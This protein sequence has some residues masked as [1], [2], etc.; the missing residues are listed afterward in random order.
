MGRGLKVIGFQNV[1]SFRDR[2]GKVRFRYRR[3][4]EKTI[5][6]PGVPGSSEFAAA[7]Q[8]ATEGGGAKLVIGQGRTKPG[9][10]NAL[11][12]AIYSSAEWSLMAKTT[13]A[14]YRGIIERLRTDYGDLPVKGIRQSHILTMRDKRAATPTA[15]NNMVKVLRWMLQ[16][17]VAR[18]MR[19]DNP[20]I[21]VKP[22]R[23]ASEGFHTWTEAEIAT[24]EA[25]WDVGT[26][27]RLAFDLL[28]YTAQRSGDVR[29]M[30]RQHLK[31]GRIQVRQEKTGA[32]LELPIHPRL[33]ASL[34]EVPANQMLFLQTQAGVG[35]TA[36][37]FGNWFREACRSAGLGHCSAHG[38]RKSAATRLADAGASEAQIMAVTG[39]QTSKEVQR[40]T[41][42]RDQIR[43]ADAAMARIGGTKTEQEM[44]NLHTQLAKNGGK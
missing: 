28:L 11:A 22:L 26:R 31:A 9:T 14:T 6:L 27:E 18:Q 35:F 3:K 17:A 34:S 30:G 36:G 8:A 21:G 12:V 41:R 33:A 29:Q 7:Y 43:L 42:K 40:Y 15:A 19:D 39:H 4:G 23:I 2:H 38:L 20:A 16:F 32:E 44:A 13:Q 10:I 5:Y 37:G 25:R 24:F 1:T